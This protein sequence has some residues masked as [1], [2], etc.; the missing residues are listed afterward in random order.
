MSTDSSVSSSGTERE[1]GTGE[2][3]GRGR[4]RGMGE[5]MGRGRGRGGKGRGM[6]RE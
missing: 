4:E 1:R 6:E 3:M 5:E 2:E